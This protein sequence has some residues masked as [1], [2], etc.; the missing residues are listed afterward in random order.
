M[1]K[2]LL[3]T[4]SALMVGSMIL[5]GCGSD[6]KETTAS[7]GSAE[8]KTETTGDTKAAS[9]EGASGEITVVSRE[10]GSGTRGA[11]V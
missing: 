8:T 3:V 6:K 11:F 10:D 1:K 5:T 9:S 7:S 2:S 4:I